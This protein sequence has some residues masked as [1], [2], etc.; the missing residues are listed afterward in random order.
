MKT[1]TL[2]FLTWSTVILEAVAQY[3]RRMIILAGTGPFCQ[4]DP[5]FLDPLLGPV[6]S[7]WTC[8]QI[9]S[10]QKTLIDRK[11]DSEYNIIKR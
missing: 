7:A 6:G 11:S 5:L 4:P 1:F 10:E 9:S 8:L 3:S 2:P